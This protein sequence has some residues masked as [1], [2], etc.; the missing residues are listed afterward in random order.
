M[1]QY[2]ETALHIASEKGHT[3]IVQVLLSNGSD[4]NRQNK[5]NRMLHYL[6]HAQMIVADKAKYSRCS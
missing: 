6:V 2:G 5:V 1:L 4:I 3:E